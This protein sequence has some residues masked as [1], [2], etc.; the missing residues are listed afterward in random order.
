MQT[1]T[2]AQ[3]SQ[4]LSICYRKVLSLTARD[5]CQLSR[6]KSWGGR[7]CRSSMVIE[8]PAQQQV[9]SY[10]QQEDLGLTPSK[11]L[12]ATTCRFAVQSVDLS[13]KS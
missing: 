10:M 9:G 12:Q 3:I 13:S 5:R 8:R 6:I 1:V 4:K 7:A 2:T 11:C